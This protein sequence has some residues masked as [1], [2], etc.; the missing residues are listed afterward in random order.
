MCR[1][2][3]R[4]LQLWCKL[5]GIATC[6]CDLNDVVMSSKPL[7]SS[8]KAVVAPNTGNS[9]GLIALLEEHSRVCVI[10]VSGSGKGKLVNWML[11]TFPKVSY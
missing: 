4:V 5:W 9:K 6:H 10:G 1:G 8:S 3:C 2:Q 11:R 7:N